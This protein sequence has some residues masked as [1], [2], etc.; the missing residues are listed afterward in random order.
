MFLVEHSRGNTRTERPSGIKTPTGKENPD[1]LRDEKREPDTDGRHIRRLMLLLGEHEDGKDQFRGKHRL[2]E[3]AAGDG[4]IGG[5]GSADVVVGGEEDLGEEGGEDGADELGA[6]EEE[7]ADVVDRVGHDHAEGDCGI[8]FAKDKR[9]GRV[10]GL[11][12]P[13]G[14]KISF[15]NRKGKGG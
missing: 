15:L 14:Q 1:E 12:V 10:S 6:D 11:C 3:D 2:D 13:N 8:F 9:R 7:A 5:Q 4:G